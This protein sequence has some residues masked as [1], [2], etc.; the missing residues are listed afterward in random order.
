MCACIIMFFKSCSVRHPD[1]IAAAR[2]T[3]SGVRAARVSRP[4]GTVTV[5]TTVGTGRTRFVTVPARPT[6]SSVPTTC[7]VCRS[8]GAVTE[9]R[10]AR[11]ALMR[12]PVRC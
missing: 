7:S 5:T 11:T 3:S 9:S 1:Q 12:T 6:T 10:T 8:P 4:G 2:A